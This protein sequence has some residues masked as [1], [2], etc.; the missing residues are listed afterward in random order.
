MDFTQWD[1]S[2]LLPVLHS[3]VTYHVPY[4][5][6]SPLG[7]VVG[8]PCLR[9]DGLGRSPS[10]LVRLSRRRALGESRLVSQGT[11]AGDSFWRTHCL[12]KTWRCER[13]S[14]GSLGQVKGTPQLKARRKRRIWNQVLS[15]LNM[16]AS[17]KKAISQ[18]THC[19]LKHDFSFC[20][21]I[22]ICICIM[23]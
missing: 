1:G 22:L 19:T 21:R 16:C 2:F 23:K 14:M 10:G 7:R 3:L 6:G 13:A 20:T 11:C 17:L 15:H 8:E 9:A 4:W 12:V 18:P 5:G